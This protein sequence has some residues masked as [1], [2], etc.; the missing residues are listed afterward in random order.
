MSH[1]TKIQSATLFA[2]SIFW[3]SHAI[4]AEGDLFYI[5]VDADGKSIPVYNKSGLPESVTTFPAPQH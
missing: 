4:S 1:S 5:I 3:A 2:L